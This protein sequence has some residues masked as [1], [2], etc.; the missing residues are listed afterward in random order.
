[1]MKFLSLDDTELSLNPKQ[2]SKTTD[3]LYISHKEL[4]LKS[5]IKYV[6]SQMLRVV[7]RDDTAYYNFDILVKEVRKDPFTQM[8]ITSVGVHLLEGL[9]SVPE[10]PEFINRAVSE[11]L[12]RELLENYKF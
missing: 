9:D 4:L 8:V 11:T 5:M 1:M 10:D 6:L 2:E 12:L 7:D 3:G